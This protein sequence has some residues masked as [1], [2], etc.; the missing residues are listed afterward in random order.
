MGL[1][2]LYQMVGGEVTGKSNNFCH[3]YLDFQIHELG[4]GVG[5]RDGVRYL[6]LLPVSWLFACHLL[7]NRSRSAV[8]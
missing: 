3:I 5:F 6:K 7:N 8:L 4:L 1:I 2:K